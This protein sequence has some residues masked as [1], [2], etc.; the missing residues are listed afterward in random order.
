MS[1][2]FLFVSICPPRQREIV[3]LRASKRRNVRRDQEK[4]S[5]NK[6]SLPLTSGAL[7]H[8]QHTGLP[9]TRMLPENRFSVMLLC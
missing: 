1:K 7:L 8:S 2:P 9:V 5:L 4:E 3:I 6:H